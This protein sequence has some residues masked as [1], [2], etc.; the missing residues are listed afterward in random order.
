MQNR[1]SFISSVRFAYIV[2]ACSQ[3]ES[4]SWSVATLN[5]SSMK[6]KLF[7]ISMFLLN[8]KKKKEKKV[9]KLRR[10]F[11]YFFEQKWIV[12]FVVENAIIGKCHTKHGKVSPFYGNLVYIWSS[13]LQ[14]SYI[15]RGSIISK[16][17]DL[18]PQKF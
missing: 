8:K 17:C 13:L 3:W 11:L 10:L 1:Y 18:M 2:S 15:V 12:T 6:C 4:A 14:F 9:A 7:Y 16:L 5:S